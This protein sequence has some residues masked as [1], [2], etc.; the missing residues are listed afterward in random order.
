MHRWVLRDRATPSAEMTEAAAMALPDV[1]IER[2]VTF[3]TIC[4]A[5]FS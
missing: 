3:C 5:T 4:E 1:P 2:K